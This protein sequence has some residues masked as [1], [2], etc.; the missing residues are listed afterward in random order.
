VSLLFHLLLVICTEAPTV[1][2]NAHSLTQVSELR[3]T[4]L[5]SM[6]SMYSSVSPLASHSDHF[7]TSYQQTTTSAGCRHLT[8]AYVCTFA[9]ISRR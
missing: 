6:L 1:H 3:S 4:P 7:L 2:R 5:D 9:L 8:V